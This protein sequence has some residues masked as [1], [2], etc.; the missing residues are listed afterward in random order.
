MKIVRSL[1]SK[2]INILHFFRL[3]STYKFWKIKA[4]GAALWTTLW[5]SEVY[6]SSIINT[7]SVLTEAPKYKIVFECVCVLES[8]KNILIKNQNT[9]FLGFFSLWLSV[10]ACMCMWY[11]QF[12]SCDPNLPAE[13]IQIYNGQRRQDIL[14]QQASLTWP[15]LKHG[16]HSALSS[17]TEACTQT[18]THTQTQT[19]CST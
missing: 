6:K 5:R 10:C 11:I 7:A 8:F 18:E 9:K 1:T 17:H 15:I 4:W 2:T 12:D 19:Q 16:C 14:T 13:V 3:F